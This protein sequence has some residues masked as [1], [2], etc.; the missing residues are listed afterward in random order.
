MNPLQ[1]DAHYAIDHGINYIDTAYPY[2]SSSALGGGMSEI[3][4]GNALKTTTGIRCI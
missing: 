4:V 1:P 2:H 3:F